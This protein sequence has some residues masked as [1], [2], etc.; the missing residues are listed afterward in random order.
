M[1]FRCSNALLPFAAGACAAFLFSA[2]PLSACQI[3]VPFPTISTADYLIDGYAVVLAR[4]DPERPFHYRSVEVLKGDPGPEKIELFLNSPTRRTLAVFPER[5]M[6]LVK[7][8][9]D[10]QASWRSTGMADEV[11]EPI[12]REI[13]DRAPLWENE[14]NT[15]ATFFS[16]YLGHADPQLRTLA[17]LEVA[18][19]PYS[20]I[21]TFGGILSRDQ[22]HAYLK[23][24][25]YVEWHALYIL[26]LAQSE[27]PTDHEFITESFHSATHF[28]STLQLAAWTTAFIELEGMAA[29]EFIEKEYFLKTSHSAKELVE[30]IRALS[31]HGTYASPAL[32]NRI[33]A[34]YGTLLT[35]SP[36]LTSQ[37]TEDLIAWERTE[38]AEEI[39][40]FVADNPLSFDLPTTLRLRAYARRAQNK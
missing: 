34:S 14:P 3:C 21:R 20:T 7:P 28:H 35:L 22:I 25:R 39:G 11:F 26:L 37:I 30:I 24:F 18:R 1:R 17:H 13:L 23:N 40:K 15:R 8:K 29:I 16:K 10:E 38:F 33:V 32:R 19:A 5:S 9:S 31:V 4:E 2:P 27:D 36:A 6:V 12:V